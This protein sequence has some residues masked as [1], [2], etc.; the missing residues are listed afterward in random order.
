[1]GG[2]VRSGGGGVVVGWG[3]DGVTMAPGGCVVGEAV[4]PAVGEAVPPEVGEAVPPAVGEAVPPEVGEA[5]PPMVGEAIRLPATT[6]PITH[7]RLAAIRAPIVRIATADSGHPADGRR[8]GRGGGPPSS[9]RSRRVCRGAPDS[10]RPR[11]VPRLLSLP[12]TSGFMWLLPS[13]MMAVGTLAPWPPDC[14]PAGAKARGAKAGLPD[15]GPA[16]AK[17]RGAKAWLPDCGPA[18][19]KAWS[20]DCGP[21]GAKAGGSEGFLVCSWASAD[22]DWQAD[23]V[24][25]WIDGLCDVVHFVGLG[26]DSP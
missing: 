11:S 3:A 22:D 4:P 8:L 1:M 15:C 19:A 6:V 17:A 16:G 21:A 24:Y 7:I 2:G 9:G 18:G 23:T 20:P 25:A 12:L 5:V 14:G 26:H 10:A 13:R